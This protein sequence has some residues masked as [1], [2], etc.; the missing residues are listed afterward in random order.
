MGSHN[1]RAQTVMALRGIALGNPFEWICPRTSGQSATLRLLIPSSGETLV[2]S[3]L[4][5]RYGDASRSNA[6]RR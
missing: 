4:S 2:A 5:T 1:I 6:R 3:G